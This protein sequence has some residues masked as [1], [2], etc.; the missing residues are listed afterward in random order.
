MTTTLTPREEF[1]A[2]ILTIAIEGGV[3]Y[4]AEVTDY[5]HGL[6][7][8][9]N[10]TTRETLPTATLTDTTD[11]ITTANLHPKQTHGTATITDWDGNNTTATTLTVNVDTIRRGWNALR[12]NKGVADR[13]LRAM[14][15]AERTLDAADI[16]A[17]VADC[18]LQA[19]MFGKVILG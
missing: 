16:D 5:H 12:K 17:E 1:Y 14:R 18:V 19:G 15:T 9:G 7:F 10:H 11:T 8:D 4:W 6:N 2:D 13:I 3:N